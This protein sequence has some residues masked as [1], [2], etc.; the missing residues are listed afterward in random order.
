[1]ED[2]IRE[3]NETI[4]QSENQIKSLEEENRKLIDTLIRH[5]K[6]K[7]DN[8]QIIQQ[9]SISSQNLST[10]SIPMMMLL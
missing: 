4:E 10:S 2:L 7:V 6:G 9:P 8:P 1:M 5:S 3:K